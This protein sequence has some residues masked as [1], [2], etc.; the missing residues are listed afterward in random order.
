MVMAIQPGEPWTVWSEPSQAPPVRPVNTHSKSGPGE[1]CWEGP[2]GSSYPFGWGDPG[3]P[4][5]G[6]DL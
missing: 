3:G 5:G 6:S 4:L 2:G 1:H